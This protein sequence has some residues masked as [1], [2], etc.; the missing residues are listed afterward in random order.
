MRRVFRTIATLTVAACLSACGGGDSFSEG[1]VF[2]T[3]T[4]EKT[5]SVANES[6][7]PSCNVSLELAYATDSGKER[8]TAINE[9]VAQKLFDMEGLTLQ[10]VADSFA[11]SYTRDYKQNIAPLYRE[12]A[13]DPLKRA[14]YEYHYNI[15]SEVKDGRKGVTVYTAIIDYYEGG[16]H[17]IYQQF[18]MNFE[19]KTGRLLQLA[20]VFVP[21]FEQPLNE[22]LLAA[23]ME[24][25][26]SKTIDDLKNKGYLY[27]MD[28]F[29]TDNFILGKD[30]I[31]FVYNPYE[32]APYSYGIVELDLDY[33]SLEDILK[34]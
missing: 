30:A 17:G 18:I 34:D 3:L 13:D 20:D 26:D 7:A 12:D 8:A 14:W 21:G 19:N 1:L 22:K 23:L 11:N 27:S 4:S 5:V 29:V 16:A 31:T 32:I 25:V 6:G 2:D 33:D 28:M 10:Q 24:M 9:A 15:N